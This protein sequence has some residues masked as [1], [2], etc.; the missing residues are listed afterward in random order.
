[1]TMY[2]TKT[3]KDGQVTAKLLKKGNLHVKIR[4]NSYDDLFKAA[5][6]KDAWDAAHAT[7]KTATAVL[8]LYCLIGQRSDRRFN[9]GESF[10][11]K[12]IA[13]FINAMQFDS[14][15]ILHPHSPISL[16]LIDNAEAISHYSF[17]EDTFNA[18]GN[19]ILVS[20]DAGAYKATHAIAEQLEADLV[21][22]NK[23]RVNGIPE[24]RI[25][26]EV[27]ERPCLI[28]DDLADGGRTFKF[29]AEALKKQGATKVYL[30]V[31]HGQFNYGFEELR[32]S[33]NHVYCTNSYKTINDSYVT[34]YLLSG[35][36]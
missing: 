21:P 13:Q 5:A 4:G 30:Y 31:T 28:V 27:A 24:I 23:V 15:Y 33:I 14:V 29:L 22:S 9:K 2:T 17:V 19:P 10:D 8:T 25:Q 34:Q 16:A 26:G 20:P 7:D 12:I 11:L 18:I 36:D 6:I 3:F 32:T 35:I 1:M